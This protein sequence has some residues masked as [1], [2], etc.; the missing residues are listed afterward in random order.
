MSWWKVLAGVAAGVV[1]T[2]GVAAVVSAAAQPRPL[3]VVPKA[4]P[5]PAPEPEPVTSG[6]PLAK[7]MIR[8]MIQAAKCDGR[9][10][11][12]EM[13]RLL[14]KSADLTPEERGFLTAQ[15]AAPFDAEALIGETPRGA[16]ER[17]YLASAA[18]IT[19]D[20][21]VE[22]DYLRKLAS[23]FGLEQ[24]VRDRLHGELGIAPLPV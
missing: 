16:E 14:V 20:S 23:A 1:V 12:A 10:D 8:A 17:V 3:P 19:P 4:D 11:E 2:A 6:D 13:Q 24:V 5:E 7:L 15:I 9:I 18:A 21:V 22:Q